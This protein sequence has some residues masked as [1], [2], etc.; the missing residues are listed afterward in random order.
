MCNKCNS[1]STFILGALI[2]AA[3]GILYAPA[4]GETT[5]K[6]VKKWAKEA[7]A[8][9]KDELAERTEQLREKLAGKTESA[10][11]KAL[12]MKEKVSEKAAELKEQAQEKIDELREKTAE[13]LEKV[14]KKLR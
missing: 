2:G 7:Y 8:D 11:E 4:K 14:V 9:S 12:E 6:K 1:I 13:Q 3:V 5:R 10:K